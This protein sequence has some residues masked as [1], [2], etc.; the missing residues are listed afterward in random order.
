ME[1]EQ[2]IKR[3]DWLDDERRK[4]KTTIESLRSRVDALEAIYT[5]ISQQI[6]ELNSELGRLQS[7]LARFDQIEAS[8]S[9]LR[10]D[11][12]RMIE[13]VEKSRA[14]HDREVEKVRRSD[15]EAIN[16]SL[17]ELRKGLEAV[18]DLKKSLQA[19]VEEDFRLARLIEEMEQKMLENTRSDEEYRRSL[20]LLEDGFRQDAKRITDMNGELSALRKRVDEQRGKVDLMVD[21]LRKLEV[22]LND[23]QSAELDRKQTQVAF[24]EKQNLIQVDRERAWKEMQNRFEQISNQAANLD[25]QLQALETTQRSVKRSQETLDD[26]TQRFDRRLNEITEMQRLVEERFRQ[27][28]VAFKADDQKRWTNYNLGTEENQRETS[29][30]LEKIVERLRTLEETSQQVRDSISLAVEETRKRLQALMT[31]SSD[32]V[33]DHDKNHNSGRAVS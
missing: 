12:T 1:L 21:N 33:E 23:F 11:L 18:P 26:I 15:Q 29:R 32:W 25:N 24:I 27:E 19:R 13:G 17:A 6:N 7:Q 2:I 8:I 31:L 16:K 4:D 3:L 5:P 14:E 30:S 20:R 28:W 10:V 9:Q 22:R